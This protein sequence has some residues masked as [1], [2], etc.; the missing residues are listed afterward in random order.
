[1]TKVKIV[2]RVENLEEY[3]EEVKTTL[4]NKLDKRE[5][6]NTPVLGSDGLVTSD[7]IF[8]ALDKKQDNLIID[9]QLSNNSLNPIA[10]STVTTKFNE[11]NN[12]ISVVES[13]LYKNRGMQ[14]FTESGVFIVPTGVKS[15]KVTCIGGGGGGGWYHGTG[16]TGGTTSFGS[17]LFAYGGGGSYD[18]EGRGAGGSFKTTVGGIGFQG[19]NGAFYGEDTPKSYVWNNGK[20]LVDYYGQGGDGTISTYDDRSKGA[21]GGSI[22]A[23]INNLIPGESI[24]INVGVGGYGMHQSGNPGMCF[25]E[26]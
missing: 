1:M 19:Q 20:V 16:G 9:Y 2:E 3:S 21:A 13:A 8:K 11:I 17:F 7:G 6:D 15:V 25:V 23:Y 5:I 24:N 22:V 26:W 12:K 14:L 10:N 4:P 18:N